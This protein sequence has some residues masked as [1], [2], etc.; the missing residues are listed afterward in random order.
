MRKNVKNIQT[1]S[2][3]STMLARSVM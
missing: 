1:E 2:T 3:K